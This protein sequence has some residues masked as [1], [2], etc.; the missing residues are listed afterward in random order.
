MSI[1]F[2]NKQKLYKKLSIA[3]TLGLLSAVY[4]P[5]G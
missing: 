4:V 1:R 5:G 3:V 2:L